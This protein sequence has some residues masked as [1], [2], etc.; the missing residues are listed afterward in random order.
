MLK[1]LRVF[2]SVAAKIILTSIVA[3]T[4]ATALVTFLTWQTLNAEVARSLEEKTQWSLRV[5]G[6]A[7]IA[8]YPDFELTYDKNAEALKLTGPAIPNFSDNEAVDRI[9]TINKGTATVFRFDPAQNDF[10]RLSTSVKKADGSRA[11][12]TV[13]G[14]KGIVFPVVMQGQIYMGT[15]NILGIPY[16]TGYMPIMDKAG[17]ITGVLYVGVGKM[18]DLRAYTDG[19]YRDM[20]IASLCILFLSALGAGFISKRLMAPLPALAAL[21]QDLA[22]DKAGISIPY[23]SRRDEIGLLARSVATFQSAVDERNVLRSREIDDKRHDLEKA[24]QRD[25]DIQSFRGAVTDIAKRIANGSGEMDAAVSQ[26]TEV[27]RSTATGADGA[28]VAAGQAT[29]GIATV[30]TSAGQLNASIRE[31]AHRAE[32]STRI[33]SAAVSSGRLSQVGVSELSKAAHK[34]GE[35]VVVIRGIAEQTNLL[36]LNATIEAARAGESGRGFAVVASEVKTLATQTSKATEEIAGHIGQIQDA[37]EGVVGTFEAIIGALND[38]ETSSGAIATSV[39]EQGAATNEIARSA[40]QAADG[41]EEMSRNVLG[42]EAMA[43]RASSA[44]VTLGGTAKVFRTETDQLVE[45]IEQFLK[46]VA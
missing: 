39:E 34:I 38:I 30:A 44:M 9:T 21:T 2:Q 19:L 18:A 5:A 17:K 27:V 3:V 23:Q 31:V 20:A 6:E 40:G 32:E 41:A 35:V 24:K 26:L 15:A 29:L 7:F 37:T 25:V 10:V 8:F 46:K 12:G 42:V 28:K 45:T 11:I 14:N 33:V 43:S 36:A 22:N 4:A 1:I 16:Q 13:L